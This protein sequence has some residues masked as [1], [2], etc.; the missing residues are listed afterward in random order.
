M[1]RRILIID[2]NNLA[3][4]LFSLRKNSRVTLAEAQSLADLLGAYLLANPAQ[5]IHMELFFDGGLAPGKNTPARLQIIPAHDADDEIIQRV[6]TGV[7]D[8]DQVV[9][10][11]G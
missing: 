1:N 7:R 9:V 8:H 11:S 10:V 4:Q 2:G 3:H 5:R 6:F